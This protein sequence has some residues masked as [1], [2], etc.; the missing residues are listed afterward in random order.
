MD[1]SR[2]NRLGWQ[3]RVGLEAGLAL[4]YADFCSKQL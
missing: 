4:A 2:L 1:S 3:P